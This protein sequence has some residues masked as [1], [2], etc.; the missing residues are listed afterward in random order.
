MGAGNSNTSENVKTAQVDAN[1]S[2]ASSEQP[3]AKV[4]K[5]QK[6]TRQQKVVYFDHGCGIA[7]FTVDNTV[8]V[9]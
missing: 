7:M 6:K 8:R 9:C 4:S 3:K 1:T 5:P 2:I